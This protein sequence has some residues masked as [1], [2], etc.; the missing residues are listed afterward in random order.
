MGGSG[1]NRGT[2]LWEARV[3]EIGRASKVR[4]GPH[5]P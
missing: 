4:H 2:R 5:H 1:V 3:G